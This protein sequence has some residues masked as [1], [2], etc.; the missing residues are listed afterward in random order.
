MNYLDVYFS[1]I[2]HMGETTAERIRNGGIRS[3]EKW[4]AESPHTVRDL[5]VERGIYFDG[6]ILTSKDKEYE[7][8]M[9]LN[10]SNDIPLLIGDIMNWQLDDGNIEKWIIVQEEKKVNG[11]YRTFWIIRCNYLLKWVD[12]DGHVQQSWSYFVSSLDSK[13]KGNF[14]TWHS[15]ITPQPN[16]YAEIL[17]PRYP[18]NRSTNF[19]VEEEAW[20]V[21]EYDHTSVPGVIYISLTEDK[22]NSIYD[23]VANNLAE[24]DRITQ[25]DLSIPSLI[26]TFDINEVIQPKFTLTAN[27]VPSNEPVTLIT[28]DKSIARIVN[29]QLTA[30]ANG[31]VD[32]IVQLTNHPEIQETIQIQVGGEK[33]FSA[34]IEGKA[35]IRLGCKNE[36]ILKGTSDLSLESFVGFT[37]DSTKLAK[38]E[39]ID[40]ATYSCIIK[41]NEDNELGKII[42][43]ATYNNVD[44]VK[45][46]EVIPLWR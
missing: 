30:V 24:T 40:K 9:F 19:I 16:K 3:F 18:I 2:N 27:G 20:T 6:I 36:Y 22:I 42:L 45:E 29:G 4:K 35:A 11:T 15:L 38:I 41:A 32:I 39:K 37:L 8:I 33:E 21:V 25:Y 23:D 28:T 44:Y 43:H 1:R 5:S 12:G 34:Y 14:R 46:I 31:T 10:V 17:M 13:I 26:Q 7:K